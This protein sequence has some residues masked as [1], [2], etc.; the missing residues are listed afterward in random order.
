MVLA[1]FSGDEVILYTFYPFAVLSGGG[2]MNEY[3]S[4][5]VVTAIIFVIG[6]VWYGPIGFGKKWMKLAGITPARMK[7]MK[8]KPWQAMGLGFV[9][10]LLTYTVVDAI[11][12]FA[13]GFAV[14]QGVTDG[15]W[16]IGARVGFFLWLGLVAPLQLGTFLWEGRSFKLFALNA[17]YY[18]VAFVL[19]GSLLALW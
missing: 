18:L 15:F 12:S 8:L 16:M 19:A 7:S 1:A 14:A 10:S 13:I 11:V 6:A 2:T 9:A 3:L 5:L 17:S 4:I